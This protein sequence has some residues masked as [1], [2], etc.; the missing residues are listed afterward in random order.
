MNY[1]IELL[2]L[3]VVCYVLVDMAKF[4][5]EIVYELMVD[6]KH[7]VIRVGLSFLTYILSCPRCFSFW[8]SLIWTGDIFIACVMALVINLV[9]IIEY[10]WSKTEL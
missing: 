2:Q 3:L 4:V 10:K 8:L 5:S 7:K 1:W 6:V 9:K